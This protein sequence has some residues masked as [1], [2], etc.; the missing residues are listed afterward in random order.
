MLAVALIV[1][2]SIILPK[3]LLYRQ[4]NNILGKIVSIEEN[5]TSS[6]RE[7]RTDEETDS[8]E[9]LHRKISL[10]T[11]GYVEEGMP[12]EELNENIMTMRQAVLSGERQLARLVALGALPDE[13]LDYANYNLI[14]YPVVRQNFQNRLTYSFWTIHYIPSHARGDL[15]GEFSLI[16]D[17]KNGKIYSVQWPSS[18]EEQRINTMAMGKAFAEYL[19]I[20]VSSET[21]E[22][23]DRYCV[24]FSAD[25]RFVIV[26]ELWE[27]YGSISIESLYDPIVPIGGAH[28]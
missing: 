16:V 13:V 24:L 18:K 8:I 17:G 21:V 14:A 11:G 23:D 19:N 15:R 20:E 7:Q 25:G 3:E 6:T 10:L 9:E 4:E 28:R 26:V 12:R 22:R 27:F 1:G 5:P 2:L